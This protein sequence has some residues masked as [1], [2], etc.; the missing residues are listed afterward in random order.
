M[1][2]VAQPDA[3]ICAPYLLD[4]RY[5]EQEV[6]VDRRRLGRVMVL[7]RFAEIQP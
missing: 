4:N 1:E 6:I 7:E 5:E 3:I 2:T